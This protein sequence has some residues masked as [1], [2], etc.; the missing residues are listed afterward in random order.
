M[1]CPDGCGDVITINLDSRSAK[2]WRFYRKRNQISVFPSVWRD[3]S[4]QSH[5]IIWNHSIVWCDSTYGDRDVIVEEEE[6]LRQR[7][8][9]RSTREWKHFTELA[10]ELGE[11]PW[12]VNRACSYLARH[13]RV[14]EEGRKERRG[15]FRL[16]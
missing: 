7:A 4:C 11:V 1:A 13:T 15:Y 12:D 14:L 2:A 10:E 8:F 5:F 3:T 16:V 6:Q 9:D